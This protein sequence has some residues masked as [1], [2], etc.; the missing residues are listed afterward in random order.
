MGRG[1][2]AELDMDLLANISASYRGAFVGIPIDTLVIYRIGQGER[3]LPA[4]P[5]GQRKNAVEKDLPCFCITVRN[6]VM[7]L[8]LGRIITWRLPVFS[9]LF[10]LLSASWRTEVR[11]ILAVFGDSQVAG[12]LEM[13]YLQTQ[14]VV[15]VSLRWHFEHESDPGVEGCSAAHCWRGDAYQ[16]APQPLSQEGRDTPDC[17]PPPS[18]KARG[19]LGSCRR[20]TSV[21]YLVSGWLV[22]G[23]GG[24]RDC[25][26]DWGA[27]KE[28]RRPGWS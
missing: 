26:A 20:H 22:F 28:N 19:N 27:R 23:V 21:T 4:G 18:R 8:E 17:S 24:C 7:T 6:L 13:R 12:K 11:T 3:V 16:E 9:A 14:R 25:R 2:E 15:T 10:M 1:K 5:G